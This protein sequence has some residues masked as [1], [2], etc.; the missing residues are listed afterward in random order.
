[1]TYEYEY[2][3]VIAITD[4]MKDCFTYT[5]SF[6]KVSGETVRSPVDKELLKE[7]KRGQ[8]NC[9][10]FENTYKLAYKSMEM[11]ACHNKQSHMSDIII[12]PDRIDKEVLEK[13]KKASLFTN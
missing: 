9:I 7:I 1:M 12:K 13:G 11:I 4:T 6:K 8:R 5:A 3:N 2:G 10:Y